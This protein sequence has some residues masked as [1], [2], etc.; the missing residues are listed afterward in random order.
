MRGYKRW[1]IRAAAALAVP[2]AVVLAVGAV[3]VLTVPAAMK[4][5]DVRFQASPQ[6]RSLW[7]NLGFL[8]G[9]LETRALGLGD[10][11]SYRR[12]LQLFLRVKPGKVEIYGPELENLYGK[13]QFEITRGSADDP[14]PRRRSVL[15]NL[16]AAMSLAH[17][18]SDP[19]EN[20]N[21]L[22]KA[23]QELRTAIELAPTNDD[24]KVNL[25]LALRN[26]KAQNLPGTGP[27]SGASEGSLS[28]QGRSGTGY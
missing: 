8:P 7:S 27:E 13:A 14:D 6:S 24:A 26:A 9:N 23:I 4:R 17:F 22:R 28:G 15:L 10:D 20:A 5:D 21:T 1:A 3:D 16:A 25:E 19:N 2:L 11:V 18:S 12:T